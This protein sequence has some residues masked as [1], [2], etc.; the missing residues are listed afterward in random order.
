M[1]AE[2]NGRVGFIWSLAEQLR[3]DCKRYEYG[4]VVLP[5]VVLR[6]LDCALAYPNQQ[7]IATDKRLPVRLDNREPALQTSGRHRLYNLSPLNIPRLPHEPG[8]L[9]ESLEACIRAVSSNAQD[10]LDKFVFQARIDKLANANLLTWG[11]PCRTA[12]T[13]ERSARMTAGLVVAKGS[14]EGSA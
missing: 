11:T 9:K 2:H 13:I 5:F 8:H 3:G 10:V 6:R 14:T 7:V 4:K 1:S 12:M